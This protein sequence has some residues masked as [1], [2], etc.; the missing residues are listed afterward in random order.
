[1]CT[2]R[3]MYLF[4]AIMLI[5][6]VAVTGCSSDSG[7]Q[8]AEPASSDSNDQ[9][10]QETGEQIE[11]RFLWWGS[12]DRHDRT[13][14][15]IELYEEQNPHV[16]I[17]PEFIGWDGYFDRLA[18]QV[19]AGNA[20]DIFQM[21]DRYLPMYADR[22][23]LA[24]LMP[25]V[26]SGIINVDDIALG[27]LAPGM[28]DGKLYGM[29]SGSNAFALA[30]DPSLFEQAGV[31][32]LEP[33]STWE[34]FENTARALHERLGIYGTDIDVNQAR[35]FGLYLKQQ[36][37]WL[38]NEDGT[39]LGWDNEQHY[40]D[41]VNF[42]IKLKDDG[43][44][45]PADVVET[46]QAVEDWLI[47]NERTPM[48]VIHSNQIV[49]AT[50]AADRPLKMTMLPFSQSGES[51]QYV[52]ASMFYVMNANTQHPEEVAKFIDF[53][54]NNLEANEIL[55]ADRG[56]PIS[57]QVREHLYDKVD[58]TIKQQFDYIELVIEHAS[59]SPPPPPAVSTELDDLYDRIFMEVLYGATT[60][61][62]AV[63]KYREESQRILE[64]GFDE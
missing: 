53:L 39:R 38:Y 6:T 48:Q 20:P 30:Y 60:P 61:E 63:K 12:Q 13:L 33:G 36:G 34:D 18:T 9:G 58:E 41:Y 57:A 43:V 37:E 16:K 51:G 24:D 11:L 22:G 55:E 17:T 28:I 8:S 42:W 64:R 62:D 45:P 29:N 31:D 21:V 52:R 59:E 10:S 19:A 26:E 3:K 7:Q 32:P 5:I 25:Y 2:K 49:A 27:Y 14:A 54:T 47:V 56:V 46:A 44:A 35:A 23:V 40:I 15:V 1:M 50:R 4:L